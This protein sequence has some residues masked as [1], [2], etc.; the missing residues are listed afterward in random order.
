M[1]NV[2]PPL[3]H[4]VVISDDQMSVAMTAWGS[5]VL[6]HGGITSGRHEF[7]FVI[8]Q[9]AASGGLCVGVVDNAQFDAT[10]KNVGAAPNSW[11]YS[12]SG[13][14]VRRSVHQPAWLGLASGD[15]AHGCVAPVAARNSAERW[16][17]HVC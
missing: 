11:G 6:E 17:P 15:P 8:A 9:K 7:K 12:S 5:V 13:K 4:S 2:A 10:S 16:L 14:K 1:C 3:P